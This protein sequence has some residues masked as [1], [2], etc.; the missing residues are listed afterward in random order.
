MNCIVGIYLNSLQNLYSL[1]QWLCHS[2]SLPIWEG[3]ISFL[4]TNIHF[5]LGKQ[6]LYTSAQGH[7]V[8]ISTTSILHYDWN[9]LCSSVGLWISFRKIFGSTLPVLMWKSD[10]V[11]ANDDF[12]RVFLLERSLPLMTYSLCISLTQWCQFQKFWVLV[13]YTALIWP[14][15]KWCHFTLVCGEL[16]VLVCHHAFI[17]EIKSARFNSAMVIILLFS[18]AWHFIIIL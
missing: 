15:F 11:C 10:A 12:D 17:I 2:E 18:M 7:S 1:Y 16:S 6:R 14:F 3:P 9:S 5:F 13:F 8:F 4:D